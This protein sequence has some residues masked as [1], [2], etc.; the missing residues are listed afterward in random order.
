MGCCSSVQY[1]T[2]QY[3]EIAVSRKPFGIGDIYIYT[4]LLRMTDTV[5]SQNIDLS[6]WDTLYVIDHEAGSKPKRNVGGGSESY[7]FLR[8][9]HKNYPPLKVPRQCPPVLLVEVHL[10]EGNAL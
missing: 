2:V 5:S 4:F 7:Y 10:T 1:S 3:S 9:E 8:G 6:C